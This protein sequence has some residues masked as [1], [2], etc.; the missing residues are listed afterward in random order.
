MV[1]FGLI[2]FSFTLDSINFLFQIW[3]RNKTYK[4]G[5]KINITDPKSLKINISKE[6]IYEVGK[7]AII[8]HHL[9]EIYMCAYYTNHKK[10]NI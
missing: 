5:Q 8:D 9:R 4:P 3:I 2:G 1:Q 6:S 7:D 10:T